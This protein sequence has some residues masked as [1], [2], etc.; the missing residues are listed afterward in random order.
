M[1]W[2]WWYAQLLYTVGTNHEEGFA[3]LLIAFYLTV[4]VPAAMGK[5]KPL[6][7]GQNSEAVLPEQSE[8]QPNSEVKPA[9]PASGS[10]GQLLYENHCQA[11][12]TSVVH[13]RKTHRARSLTDLT[14]WVTHWSNKLKLLW[15]A[16]EISDVVDYLNQRFYKINVPSR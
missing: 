15:S 13:V 6:P 7:K 9:V 5:M 11:C 4:I 12:H 8:V 2:L 16:D 3:T 14:Y 10:R 1:L